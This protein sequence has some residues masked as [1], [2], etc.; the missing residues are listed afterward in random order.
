MQYNL[1]R[2]RSKTH[3]QQNI[4]YYR[5][6]YDE[7]SINLTNRCPNA[8]SF[9]IRDRSFGWGFSNLYLDREPS[10]E[11]IEDAITGATEKRPEVQ[12]KK[13]KIC[14]YGEPMLRVDILPGL[15]SFLR[16]TYPISLIQLATTGWSVYHIKKGVE[17]FTDVAKNGL[18]LVYLGMHATNFQDYLRRINPSIDAQVA[19]DQV[20]EFIKLAKSLDLKVTCAFVNLGNLN[21]EEIKE[22]VQEIGCEYDIRRFENESSCESWRNNLL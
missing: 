8:C 13:F 16:E 17:N 1:G 22:F 3:A 6:G 20:I 15:V 14:G 5:R 10:L 11:E 21:L 12:V 4:V 9:C 18:D 7:V 2:L 19:F